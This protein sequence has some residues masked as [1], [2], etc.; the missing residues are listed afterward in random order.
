M[1]LFRFGTFGAILEYG[2]EKKITAHSWLGATMAV[3]VPVGVTLRIKLTRAQQTYLFPFHLS[4]EV[5]VLALKK[6]SSQT[7]LLFQI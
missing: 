3:G 6:K 4:D 7:A 5:N 2:V 1:Y